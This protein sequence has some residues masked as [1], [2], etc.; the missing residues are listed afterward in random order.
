MVLPTPMKLNEKESA[1]AA[2]AL[3]RRAVNASEANG[4]LLMVRPSFPGLAPA[5]L[6]D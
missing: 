1:D 2:G 6:H 3:A 4:N 5:L